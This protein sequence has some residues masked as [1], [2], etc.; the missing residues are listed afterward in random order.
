MAHATILPSAST[1]T[2]AILTSVCA[3]PSV[4]PA[5]AELSTFGI[6]ARPVFKPS[7]T[8]STSV[9][10]STFSIFFAA[11]PSYTTRPLHPAR[12]PTIASAKARTKDVLFFIEF[13]SCLNHH[14]FFFSFRRKSA[15]NTGMQGKEEMHLPEVPMGYIY[16]LSYVFRWLH[17]KGS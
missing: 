13:Y 3:R 10:S 14:S 6:R 5:S 7:S 1:V 11:E 8:T 4:S 12:L 17:N 2:A 9:V 15:G 16:R